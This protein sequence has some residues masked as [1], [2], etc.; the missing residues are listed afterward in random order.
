MFGLIFI[1]EGYRIIITRLKG[2]RGKQDDFLAVMTVGME[3]S[4]SGILNEYKR[5]WK[6]ERAFLNCGG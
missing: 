6:I 3:G 4:N 2:L 1:G 5:R